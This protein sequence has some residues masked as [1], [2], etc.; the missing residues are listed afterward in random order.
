MTAAAGTT[1]TTAQARGRRVQHD[2]V[3]SHI[4]GGGYRRRRGAEGESAEKSAKWSG[5]ETD[6]AATVEYVKTVEGAGRDGEQ[7]TAT[8]GGTR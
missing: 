7:R 5:K 2:Q 8:A 6:G 3:S 1:A 4:A